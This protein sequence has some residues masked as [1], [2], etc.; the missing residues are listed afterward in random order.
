MIKRSQIKR[1]N[2]RDFFDEM[3]GKQPE[4]DKDEELRKAAKAIGKIPV[5]TA[6]RHSPIVVPVQRTV[7]RKPALPPAVKT[8]KAEPAYKAQE[9]APKTDETAG[10]EDELPALP[11]EPPK[12]IEEREEIEVEQKHP[13][14]GSLDSS[15]EERVPAA[16]KEYVEPKWVDHN[17]RNPTLYDVTTYFKLPIEGFSRIVGEEE[18]SA[19]VALCLINGTPF[20]IEGKSGTCKTVM[21]DKLLNLIPEDYVKTLKLISERAANYDAQNINGKKLLHIPEINHLIPKST[22]NKETEIEKTLKLLAEGKSAELTIVRGGKAI[23]ITINPINV[24]YTRALGNAYDIRK[25]LRR[26]FVVVETSTNAEKIEQTHMAKNKDRHTIFT[27]DTGEMKLADMLGTHFTNMTNLEGV[28][29]FDPFAD[30]LFNIIPKTEKSSCYLEQ[31]YNLL[32]ACAKFHFNERKKLRV[33]KKIGGKYREK[34]V[35]FLNLEDH[36][37]VYNIFHKQFVNSLRKYEDDEFI[38][39]LDKIIKPNWKKYLDVGL[40]EM[41]NNPQVLGI[42][43]KHPDFIKDWYESQITGHSIFTVDYKTGKQEKITDI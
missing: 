27:D 4:F 18:I 10:S 3:H 32:D 24:C 41:K 16:I 30:Y 20:G 14:D 2:V 9:Q 12:E 13:L 8:P 19:V 31:Y 37:H 38:D 17:Y 5:K 40:E 26:R 43:K 23:T 42:C 28:E 1:R 36:Y 6:P 33:R 29:T 22:G 11:F 25:E 35:L 21:M 15:L 7:R 34:L 39:A